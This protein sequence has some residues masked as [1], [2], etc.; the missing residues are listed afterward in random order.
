[1]VNFMGQVDWAVGFPA[2]AKRYSECVCE[3]V[4]R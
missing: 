3:D 1:M 4:P 2:L